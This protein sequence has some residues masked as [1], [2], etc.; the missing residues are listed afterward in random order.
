MGDDDLHD[1]IARHPIIEQLAESL[2]RSMANTEWLSLPD[3]LEAKIA[4]R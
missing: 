2:D 3:E 1:Q 4:V